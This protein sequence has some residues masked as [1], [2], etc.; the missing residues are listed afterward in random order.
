MSVQRKVFRVEKMFARR[1]GPAAVESDQRH[2]E[3]VDQIKALRALSDESDVPRLRRELE[4]VHGAISHNKRELS[5]LLKTKRDEPRLE[6]AAEELTATI[7]GMESATDN[8]LKAAEAIDESVKALAAVLKNDYEHGVAHDIQDQVVRIF[9]ACNFQDLTGQR[10]AKAMATLKFI[11]EHV[12]GMIEAWG[13]VDQSHEPKPLRPD[14]TL[15]RRLA[16]GPKLDGDSGHA[17]Q[18]DI[19]LIFS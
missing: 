1:H 19:D 5:A 9:E 6:R 13:N 15:G 11:E 7:A 16:N 12:A 4:L 2:A 18:R 3:L 8:I 14:H 17:S 10:I